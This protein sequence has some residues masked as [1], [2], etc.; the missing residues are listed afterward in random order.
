MC[1]V[2]LSQPRRVQARTSEWGREWGKQAENKQRPPFRSNSQTHH[3]VWHDDTSLWPE[4][5]YRAI[6]RCIIHTHIQTNTLPLGSANAASGYLYHYTEKLSRSHSFSFLTRQEHMAKIFSALVLPRVPPQNAMNVFAAKVGV[7]VYPLASHNIDKAVLYE[8]K[9]QPCRRNTG[10]QTG[11]C[12]SMWGAYRPIKAA[13]PV[14]R[15]ALMD[16]GM[17]RRKNK[18]CDSLYSF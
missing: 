12:M 3:S 10:R 7:R 2:V 13:A 17:G 9:L 11:G 1:L 8:S 16:S 15:Q 4:Y 18:R 5:S 14:L 6:H